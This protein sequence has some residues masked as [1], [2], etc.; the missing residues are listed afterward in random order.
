MKIFDP[1]HAKGKYWAHLKKAGFISGLLMAC[2][3]VG[4]IHALVPT[5]LPE[6]IRLAVE[7]IKVLA[8]EP[9]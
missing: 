9:L 6:F 4:L 1:F 3:L 5:F 8:D 2:C 7:R